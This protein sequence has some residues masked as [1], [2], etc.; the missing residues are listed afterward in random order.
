M[1]STCREM[2]IRVC[3]VC[4]SAG[5]IRGERAVGVPQVWSSPWLPRVEGRAQGERLQE[6]MS[7]LQRGKLAHSLSWK[8]LMKTRGGNPINKWT[9]TTLYILD[10]NGCPTSTILYLFVSWAWISRTSC[11][12]RTTQTTAIG[13][14]VTNSGNRSL[15]TY[16]KNAY[17]YF[18]LKRNNWFVLHVC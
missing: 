17:K 18:H 10:I 1:N 7:S 12:I 13:T 14:D 11:M 5:G 3:T 6:N 4:P 9:V 15:S 2:G 8:T 16:L